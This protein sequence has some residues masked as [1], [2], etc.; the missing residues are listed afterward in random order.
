MNTIFK[1]KKT[2]KVK[3][4]QNNFYFQFLILSFF[5]CRHHFSLKLFYFEI[6]TFIEKER[7]HK[8]IL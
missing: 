3:Q 8:I 2:E 4:K 5:F 1:H 7:D 6:Y